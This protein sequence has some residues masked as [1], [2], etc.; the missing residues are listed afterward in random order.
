MFDKEKRLITDKI[1]IILDLHNHNYLQA[2]CQESCP[3]AAECVASWGSSRCECERGHVGGACVP[4]CTVQPCEHTGTCI[5]DP[6]DAK[7][8]KCQCNSTD[9]SGKFGFK[10]VYL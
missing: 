10:S 8:Y 9:Y 6:V 7:G 1:E 5:E 4:V 3:A 2:E